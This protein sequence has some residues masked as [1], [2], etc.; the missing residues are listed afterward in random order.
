MPDN[1]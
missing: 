1:K